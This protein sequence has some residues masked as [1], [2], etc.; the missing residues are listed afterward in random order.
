MLRLSASINH[1]CLVFYLGFIG[2]SSLQ[3]QPPT[4]TAIAAGGHQSI[5][6]KDDGTVL[7]W[8]DNGGG[9]FDT[10]VTP[11]SSP[12]P[13][14]G[15]DSIVDIA[16][17]GSHS[18]A[19]RQDGTVW[20]WGRNDYGQL[21]DQTFSSSS[22]PVQVAGLSDIIAVVAGGY[23][24]L[25]LQNNGTIWTWGRN[26]FGQ[27]GQFRSMSGFNAPLSLSFTDV[28]SIA[29]GLDFSFVV[30][31]DGTV[32]GFGRNETGQL[33][34][35]QNAVYTSLPTQVQKL[36]NVVEVAAGS[37]HALALS[38]DGTI[39]A[40]G[41]NKFGK[42]GNG[43]FA[44][45]SRTPVKVMA[46][47]G[48]T[49]IA[50]GRYHSIALRID[51]TVWTWGGNTFGQLG[52]GRSPSSTNVAFA[53]SGLNGIDVAAGSVHSLTLGAGGASM[54]AWGYNSSGQLGNATT[55]TSKLPIAMASLY[56]DP[57]VSIVLDS[58]NAVATRTPILPGVRSLLAIDTD[59]LSKG[60]TS[61]DLSILMGALYLEA[62]SQVR[63]TSPYR[64]TI[65]RPDVEAALS[66][67]IGTFSFGREYLNG[68]LRTTKIR[69]ARDPVF[70]E[71]L[72]TA[73]VSAERKPCLTG[74][75]PR[76]ICGVM[77]VIV[78]IIMVVILVENPQDHPSGDELALWESK[79]WNS[80]YSDVGLLGYLLG[81][82]SLK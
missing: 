80:S 23:H 74:H 1:A 44:S 31:S 17:G 61:E 22:R 3:A 37:D 76:W 51:G 53:V 60:L 49:A 79:A 25:A 69:L 12:T 9:P 65:T 39:W 11:A 5:A 56:D 32:W 57:E 10:N 15:L 78:V 35:G 7:V 54:K 46:P 6:L 55:V 64:P 29:A 52:I 42:L 13:L 43:T 30:R 21:G 36:E 16:A 66:R 8:G 72:E 62:A 77:V 41:N 34:N 24:S 4:F 28:V 18:L 47:A 58:F 27:L 20:A 2:A 14:S 33:G 40:W 68:M 63:A 71:Q 48:M 38:N 81:P 26:D 82:A 75:T 45:L 59:N 50:A 73:R 67:P 70:R 19:L